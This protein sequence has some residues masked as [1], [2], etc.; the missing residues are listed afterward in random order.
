MGEMLPFV[1]GRKFLKKR[2]WILTQKN[3]GEKGGILDK[4]KRKIYLPKR[5]E[6]R[7]LKKR[8]KKGG[9]TLKNPPDSSSL[10]LKISLHPWIH[11][12]GYSSPT[13]YTPFCLF[14]DFQ[15]GV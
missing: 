7:V 14:S 11:R 8:E 15:M 10:P 12:T 5:K 6:K 4:K 3:G 1:E 9:E 2:G 13:R